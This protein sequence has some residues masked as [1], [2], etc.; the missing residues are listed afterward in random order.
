MQI[1]YLILA[2]K[3]PEQLRRLVNKLN[4]DKTSFY[5]HIDAK[6]ENTELFFNYLSGFSK[7]Q[8]I[9]KRVKVNWGAFSMVEAT[10]N[11]LKEIVNTGR[12]YDYVVLMSGQDYPI[13]SNHFIEQ[14]Y[15]KY[16]GREFIKYDSFPAWELPKGG[17]DRIDYYYDYDNLFSACYSANADIF[18]KAMRERR[19]KRRFIPGM[20]PYSGSQWWSLTL[21]CIKSIINLV[22]ANYEIINFYRYSKF[23]ASQVTGPTLQANAN[24]IAGS[25]PIYGRC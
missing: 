2:H 1:A 24:I 18:E 13:K 22:N 4:T 9:Q 16:R 8:Y 3:N 7:V 10:L 6:V 5:I 21:E 15:S 17:M 20:V 14:Y 12:N 11:S 23:S 19:A 25:L